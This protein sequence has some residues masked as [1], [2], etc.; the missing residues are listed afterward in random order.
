MII[1][2]SR[3]FIAASISG[4]KVNLTWADTNRTGLGYIVLRSADGG[5][6]TQVATIKAGAARKYTDAAVAPDTL[7]SYRIQAVAGIREADGAHEPRRALEDARSRALGPRVGRG[8]R[9][10]CHGQDGVPPAAHHGPAFPFEHR[11]LRCRLNHC[12][13]RHRPVNP[14]RE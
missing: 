1:K 7:Y 14:G 13:S 2:R 11:F 12:G 3:S 8:Q 9:E 4:I 5:E 10:Q 6:Y